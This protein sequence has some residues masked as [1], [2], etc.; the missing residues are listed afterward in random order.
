MKEEVNII[1]AIMDT[2]NYSY[3]NPKGTEHGVIRFGEKNTITVKA[4]NWERAWIINQ[5]MRDDEN[6][7][8]EKQIYKCK[9]IL[10]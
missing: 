7:P 10:F 3:A 9:K 2:G 4:V 6:K 8:T 1:L 5:I